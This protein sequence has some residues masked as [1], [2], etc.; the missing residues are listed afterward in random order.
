MNEWFVDESW[1]GRG[2]CRESELQSPRR[3]IRVD[4]RYLRVSNG[5]AYGCNGLR[6]HRGRIDLGDGIYRTDGG[7]FEPVTE[8]IQLPS[9]AAFDKV[10]TP[11][12]NSTL[13]SA[14]YPALEPISS[15]PDED[16]VRLPCGLAI[17][18]QFLRDALLID[19]SAEPDEFVYFSSP[20]TEKLMFA[21]P[22]LIPFLNG[23]A[24]IMPSAYNSRRN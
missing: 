1:I 17:N 13:H 14:R 19:G 21:P 15:R 4:L 8:D 7:S 5:V 2:V 20:F 10:V 16:L 24:A 23:V 6:L 18:R 12:D 9:P 3:G 11:R 22:V